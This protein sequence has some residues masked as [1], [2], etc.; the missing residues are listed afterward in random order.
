MM[1]PASS[2]GTMSAEDA[3]HAVLGKPKTDEEYF[4]IC[5]WLLRYSTCAKTQTAALIVQ[6]GEIISI[7]ANVCCPQGQ[8]Y[9]LP[10][11]ECPRMEKATGTWYEFCKPIHA[12]I[13]A[14]LNALGSSA[15]ERKSLWHFPRFTLRFLHY[16]G[17]FKDA[18]LYLVGH[19][20][21]CDECVAFAKLI[22]I[23][24]IKFDNLSGGE[25]LARYQSKKLTADK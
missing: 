22:G 13:V 4:A 15:V 21:A 20:W 17:F 23:T 2:C 10:V 9:G 25:T 16:Q 7:G 18:T 11:N 3:P 5:R 12:E 24:E 6:N 19:Y 8:L 1:V 14:C